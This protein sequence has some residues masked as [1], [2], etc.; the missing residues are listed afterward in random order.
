MGECYAKEIRSEYLSNISELDGY[1]ILV[2][3][4][5]DFHKNSL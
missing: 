5:F 2:F 1:D 4:S 3:G